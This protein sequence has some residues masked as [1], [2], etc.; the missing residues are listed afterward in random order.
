M[1]DFPSASLV[2]PASGTVN[3]FCMASLADLVMMRK[4]I[5]NTSTAWTTA[6]R[7]IYIPFYIEAPVTAF[8]MAVS[9]GA[10]VAGNLD[11]GIYDVLGNKI[12]TKGTTVQTGASVMQALDITDTVLAPG[13][14]FMAMS[15]DSTTAT[16]IGSPVISGTGELFRAFGVQEQLT[17]FPLPATATFANPASTTTTMPSISVALKSVI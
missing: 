7:A 11:L 9:N 14:Y 15:T 17:A 10:T 16:Y 3:A 13:T 2:N 5:F 12:V 8:Q 1:A 6:N 4:A